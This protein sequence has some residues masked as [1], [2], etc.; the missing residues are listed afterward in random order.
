MCQAI[1]I[2]ENFGFFDFFLIF[3]DPNLPKWG[4]SDVICCSFSK[5]K[6]TTCQ[7]DTF[8]KI[9]FSFFFFFFLLSVKAGN[10]FWREN[11]FFA[12]LDESLKIKLFESNFCF[13]FI[14]PLKSGGNF[15]REIFFY[16]ISGRITLNYVI[17]GQL[18]NF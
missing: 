17:W 16:R 18:F 5:A 6:N 11:V 15:W 9:Q 3:F 10:F 4:K 8:G 1:A 7:I 14:F 2:L 12:F 13:Y